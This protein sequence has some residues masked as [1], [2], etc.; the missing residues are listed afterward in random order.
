MGSKTFT[1]EIISAG[2]I[3]V[4]RI[5]METE[6]LAEGDVVDVMIR[7]VKKEQKVPA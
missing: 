6:G 4:P 1:A 3:T 7:L 5:I 2:R